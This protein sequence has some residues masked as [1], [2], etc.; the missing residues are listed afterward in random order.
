MV[1]LRRMDSLD[2]MDPII[3]VLTSACAQYLIYLDRK[4]Y[5]DLLE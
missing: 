2:D 3:A 5:W 1:Y 4:E